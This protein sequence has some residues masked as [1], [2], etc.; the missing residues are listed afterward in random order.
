MQRRM[1]QALPIVFTFFAFAFPSGLVLYWVT[2]NLL[3]MA[4]QAIMMKLKARR[5]AG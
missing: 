4:Q 1:M 3:S 2:N 5:E